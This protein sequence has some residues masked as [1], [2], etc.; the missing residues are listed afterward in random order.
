MIRVALV[1]YGLAGSVFHGPF[2]A[3]DPSF[4]VVAVA[5]RAAGRSRRALP[6]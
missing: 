5:T 2:L 3:A 6:S 1:G 4:E